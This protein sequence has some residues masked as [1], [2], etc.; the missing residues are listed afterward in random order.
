MIDGSKVSIL[1]AEDEWLEGT[2]IE[3]IEIGDTNFLVLN[4]GEKNPRLF[5]INF[6][7]EM[8]IHE[9]GSLKQFKPKIVTT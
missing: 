2:I 9:K 1:T 8:L 3:I 5:N 4:I 7:S 6:I